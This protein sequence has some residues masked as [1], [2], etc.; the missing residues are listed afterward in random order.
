MSMFAIPTFLARAGRVQRV[1]KRERADQWN[2]RHRHLS[3]IVSDAEAR[4]L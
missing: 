3:L 2:D 4:A 1:H